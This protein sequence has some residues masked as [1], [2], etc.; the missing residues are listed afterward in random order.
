MDVCEKNEKG[1]DTNIITED[2][3]NM[4][5]SFLQILETKVIENLKT[6]VPAE[7]AE[8]EIGYV[9]QLKS[10]IDWS[11]HCL[12]GLGRRMPLLDELSYEDAAKMKK[13][14]QDNMQN[15][16]QENQAQMRH[17]N[18]AQVLGVCKCVAEDDFYRATCSE[19]QEGF[20]MEQIEIAI[21]TR[22]QEQAQL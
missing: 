21:Y 15:L 9:N 19:T 22:L 5:L 12:I 18:E 17:M 6:V 10:E 1:E 11:T 3:F 8:D 16:F 13:L 4:C 2:F 7:M 20:E 14:I